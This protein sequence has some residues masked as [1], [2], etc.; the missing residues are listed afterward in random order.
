MA[1]PNA[2]DHL[3]RIRKDP[4]RKLIVVDPR[5]SETAAMADVHVA[6]RPGTDAFFL[7]GLL[8]TLVRRDAVDHTFLVEHT[9][10][11][12]E[13]RR[14]LLAIPVAPWAAP[15]KLASPRSSAVP[16]S[17]PRPRRWSCGSSSASSR[18]ATP[19]LS[20]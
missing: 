20:C 17:S 5:R 10:G 16:I 12:D 15:P 8:A 14:A 13:V 11:F 1:S 2:R 9:L 4:A 18:A 19:L 3:N 6:L 7:A